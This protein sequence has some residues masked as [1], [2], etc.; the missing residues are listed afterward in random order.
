MHYCW[1]VLDVE[2]VEL[3]SEAA[4]G[5]REVPESFESLILPQLLSLSVSH[6]RQKTSSGMPVI[7]KYKPR[8]KRGAGEEGWEPLL[9]QLIPRFYPP[10]VLRFS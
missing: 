7:S 4:N 6:A 10:L 5:C 8:E 9:M 2:L 3:D 1:R